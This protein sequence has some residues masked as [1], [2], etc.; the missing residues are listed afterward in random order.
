MCLQTFFQVLGKPMNVMSIYYTKKVSSRY[1]PKTAKNPW[2]S[3]ELIHGKFTGFSKDIIGIFMGNIIRF[4][5][6]CHPG[7]SMKKPSFSFH[8]PWKTLTFEANHEYSWKHHENL[9]LLS[10][11]FNDIENA[12]NYTEGFSWRCSSWPFHEFTGFMAHE[13]PMVMLLKLKD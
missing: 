11:P 2:K 7:K 9:W 12:M 1:E 3:S 6:A 13:K 5:M 10:W 4:F 8:G